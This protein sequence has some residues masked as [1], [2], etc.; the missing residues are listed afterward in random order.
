MTNPELI[1]STIDAIM[2]LW[3]MALALVLKCGRD[4]A[5]QEVMTGAVAVATVSVIV[6]AIF[7]F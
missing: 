2:I 1:T 6:Y 7:R 3:L 5:D 4:M